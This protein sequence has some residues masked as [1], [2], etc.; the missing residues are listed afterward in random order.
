MSY[1]TQMRIG[2]V[3]LVAGI[4]MLVCV[5]SA[6]VLQSI[7]QVDID[8]YPVTIDYG[9]LSEEQRKSMDDILTAA[10]NGIGQINVC[11]MTVTEWHEVLTHIGMYFGSMEN[12]D[13]LV[14]L[15]GCKATLN[16]DL[17]L[18][19]AERKTIIDARIDEA[20]STIVEGSDRFKLWQISKYIA[21][22]ITYTDGTR[23]T[24]DGLNG[25]GV[26]TTYS[27]IFYKMA[28]RLGIQTYIC[29]GYAGEYHS[30]NMVELYGEKRFYDVTWY[31]GDFRNVRYLNDRT[32]WWRTFQVNNLWWEERK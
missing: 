15:D 14:T 29:C 9:T 30:W 26:C 8:N 10:E 5:L 16:L 24:L 11:P 21:D 25:N 1:K 3:M 22:R 27:M 23:E 31:D 19:F 28:T 20:V 18:I 32:S 6:L 12:I 4:L 7:K 17:F 2:T 13:K